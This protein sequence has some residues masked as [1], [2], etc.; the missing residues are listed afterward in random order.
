MA[1]RETSCS[2]KECLGDVEKGCEGWQCYDLRK[3]QNIQTETNEIKQNNEDSDKA[4]EVEQE[5]RIQPS[6]GDYVAAVY[7]NQWYIG[8]VIE[9]DEDEV[10][11]DFM[12]QAGKVATNFKW[13]AL[14][15]E[16][17]VPVNDILLVISQPTT[18][19]KSQRLYKLGGE[20]V[21]NIEI[22]FRQRNPKHNL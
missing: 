5:H 2:C 15:D 7:Q 22:C 12:E 1:V 19:G 3:I 16:L 20:I 10:N 21:D 4:K 13:P 17:W 14:K 18:S 9:F 6:V 8:K 11:I